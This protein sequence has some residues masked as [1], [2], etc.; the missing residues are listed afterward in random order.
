[1][2]VNSTVYRPEQ[3][4][5]LVLS[6]YM[7]CAQSLIQISEAPTLLQDFRSGSLGECTCGLRVLR[8]PTSPTS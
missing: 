7:C 1:M 8:L 6:N 5:I 3:V 2:K 4:V